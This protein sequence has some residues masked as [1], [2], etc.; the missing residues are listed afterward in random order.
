MRS[1]EFY[2]WEG[3]I[4]VAPTVI[5]LADALAERGHP[6]TIYT[7]KIYEHAPQPKLNPNIKVVKIEL[8]KLVKGIGKG[9]NAA[10]F[11]K[12]TSREIMT[13]KLLILYFNSIVRKTR[14][15]TKEK[16]ALL[17]GIDTLGLYWANAI[18]NKE[19]DV[20][21]L[22]LELSI[23]PEWYHSKTIDYL[24]RKE[25]DI[26]NDVVALT[27]I[28]DKYRL[29]IL[30]RSN[31]LLPASQFAILTNSPRQH[32]SVDVTE[33]H[34]FDEKFLLPENSFKLL[35]AG[36]ISEAM[37]STDIAKSFAGFA[38]KSIYLIF[39]EREKVSP[40]NKYIREVQKSGGK[41]LLLSLNPVPYEDLYKVVLSAHIGLVFYN[42]A[43]GENFSNIVGASGK[44]SH[45]LK[46]SLPVI[47][48]DLPGFKELIEKYQCGVVIEK[49]SQLEDAVG[50]VR[51]NYHSMKAGAQKCYEECYNF[52]HQLNGIYTR[53]E[54]TFKK[55]T[56][57]A[58]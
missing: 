36:A 37:L 57:N 52:D 40:E 6:V 10:I 45:Y 4:S 1:I 8:N 16:N 42:P 5:N 7:R 25:K 13:V 30:K 11:L 34:F 3:Y 26:H 43:Y 19:N 50:R 15:K 39:H 24:K 44:L 46:F 21:Y 35:S 29:E 54:G 27:L 14:R 18:K 23:P 38:D 22:S 12:A 17:I 53:W 48:L 41:N 58:N 33:Q 2:F 51:Q 56:V 28:Q 49:L 20:F 32:R 9:I 31:N 55:R 47:C